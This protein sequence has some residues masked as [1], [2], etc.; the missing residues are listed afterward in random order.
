M[1]QDPVIGIQFMITR[2]MRRIL[3]EDLGYLPSDIDMMEPQITAVVI[4]KKLP[5]PL[6]GMPTSW[7]RDGL[8]S[9]PTIS[10]ISPIKYTVKDILS[11]FINFI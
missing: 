8:E 10:F 1:C 7:I 3:V 11:N 6:N 5:R 2:R 4:D 9:N